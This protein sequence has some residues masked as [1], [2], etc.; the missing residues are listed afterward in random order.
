MRVRVAAAAAAAA[1]RGE[2]E[3]G[4]EEKLKTAAA[5][6]ALEASVYTGVTEVD[7]TLGEIASGEEREREGGRVLAF[8]V[9]YVN[10]W[11]GLG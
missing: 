7:V 5:A 9:P 8:C 4:K 10:V 3:Q 6:A 11:F 1:A 2:G